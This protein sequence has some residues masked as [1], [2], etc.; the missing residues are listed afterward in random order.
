MLIK[1]KRISVLKMTEF[2]IIGFMTNNIL[3]ARLGEFARALIISGKEKISARYSFAS[4]VLERVF[5][6]V[7]IVGLLIVLALQQPFPDWVRYM[8]ILAAAV[9]FIGFLVLIILG[10]RGE[11]WIVS[12]Q[13]RFSG[14]LIG[15]AAGFMSK[16][17]KGLEI[18]KDKG[19]IAVI[20]FL[21]CIIWAVEVVNYFLVMKCFGIELTI[22]AA[23][24]V[25]VVAN[26]GI[27][28]PSSPGNVGTMH[29]FIILG[30]SVYKIGKS[31]ALAYAIVLHAAMYLSIT[32]IGIVLLSK[33]GLTLHDIKVRGSGNE[34][35]EKSE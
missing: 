8:G 25:L 29:A 26:L 32:V 11:L 17:V 27:M 15:K 1:V 5:D 18:L 10:H 7:T 24:F 6:G 12:L 13:G 21:S 20:F 23:A 31:M 9:F 30:L 35:L 14:G 2:V 3:P 22:G 34:D 33:I 28:I 16:F 19:Q 4:V